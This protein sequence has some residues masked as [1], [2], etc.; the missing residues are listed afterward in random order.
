MR[1][2][3]PALLDHAAR[4]R[5]RPGSGDAHPG[6]ERDPGRIAEPGRIGD[7]RCVPIGRAPRPRRRLRLRPAP[8]AGGWTFVKQEKCPESRFECVTLSVPSDH[9]TQGSAPWDVTFAIQRATGKRLGTFVTIAGGPGGSG[10]A[11]ADSY[12]DG[13]PASI[14]EHYDIVYPDQRGIGLSHPIGCPDA[15]AAYY[16][17]PYEPA[18]AGRG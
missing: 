7:T 4:R 11:V 8:S 6:G 17:S 1:V 12:T 13:E 15:T 16:S 3:A 14:A 2:V 18:G 5:G 10:I 9:F